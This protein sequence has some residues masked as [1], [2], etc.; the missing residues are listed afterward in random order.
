MDMHSADDFDLV[1]TTVII[2][3]T[4]WFSM[5]VDTVCNEAAGEVF[6]DPSPGK[7]SNLEACK[8][9]CESNPGCQS[10]SLYGSRWCSLYST[11]C[12]ETAY[13]KNGQALRLNRD[14]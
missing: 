5:G 1:L 6:I 11:R 8:A 4:K 10:I 2:T 3:A 9:A 13:N 14:V 12:E 7:R